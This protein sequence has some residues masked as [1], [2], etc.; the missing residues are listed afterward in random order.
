MTILD[1]LLNP[2]PVQKAWDYYDNVQTKDK[3]CHSLL[4]PE[5]KPAI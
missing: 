5:D 1:I 2:D 3:K 4:R